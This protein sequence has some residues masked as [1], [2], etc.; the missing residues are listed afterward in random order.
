MAYR[1]ET[2]QP[3]V[4]RMSLPVTGTAQTLIARV[5]QVARE[6]RRLAALPAE[7]LEDLGIAA[8]EAR[9]EAARP[10]WDLPANR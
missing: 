8:A 6:R 1:I 7:A 9:R 10:F 2:T 4:A 3:R 5:L